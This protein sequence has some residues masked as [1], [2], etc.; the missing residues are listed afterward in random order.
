[1]QKII[2]LLFSLAFCSCRR[3]LFV[4]AAGW[5]MSCFSRQVV[6]IVLFDDI[7]GTTVSRSI[8]ANQ[9]GDYRTLCLLSHITKLLLRVVQERIYKKIDDEVGETQFGF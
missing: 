6:I 7:V 1:M 2:A 4:L 8:Q 9:C 5:S 3:A